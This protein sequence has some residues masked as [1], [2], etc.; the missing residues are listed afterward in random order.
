MAS[1]AGAK[2]VLS[3]RTAV[4]TGKRPTCFILRSGNANGPWKEYDYLLAEALEIVE[5]ESCQMCGQ[6]KWLCLGGETEVITANGTFPIRDIVG[7]QTLLT[8]DPSGTG[9]A[10]WVDAEIRSFGT[11]PLM[12]I[13]LARGLEKK[14]IYATPEHR[15]FVQTPVKMVNGVRDW[16]SI[17]TLVTHDLKPGDALVR[18]YPQRASKVVLSPVGVQAG[19][20]FGDGHIANDQGRID[21]FGAKDRALVPYFSDLQRHDER[22]L[23]DGY[24]DDTKLTYYGFPKSWKRLPNLDE[25]SVYLRSWLA[26]YFAADGSVSKTG[27]PII[28]CASRDTLER[29]RDIATACGIATYGVRTY[30]R[31][32]INGV[33]SDLSHLGLVRDTLSPEFFIGDEHKARFTQAMAR[34]QRQ[35]PQWKVVSVSPTDRVEEVFCAT[36]PNTHAFVLKDNILTGNCHSDSDEIQFR[37]T[38]DHCYASERVER[39][40]KR[41][42]EDK[43]YDGAGVRL[44]A[45]PYSTTGKP[46]SEYRESYYRELIAKHKARE[47][48]SED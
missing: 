35:L 17:K 42:A 26:G 28:S 32:G 18:A 41:N 14:E 45:V 37:V 43:D 19:F 40:Q 31:K 46:L 2:Y 39:R 16:K 12:R 30:S 20:M 33:E 7:K 4:K 21:L 27:M 6:P 48:T 36:V 8:R 1:T 10:R 23:G 24:K 11:Q 44:Q 25:G 47:V 34:K 3:I 5:S 22:N 13:E 38:D 15:W 9:P 29:V